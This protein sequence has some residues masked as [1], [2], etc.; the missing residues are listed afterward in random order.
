MAGREYWLVDAGARAKL[1]GEVE[2]PDLGQSRWE[3]DIHV[4][5]TGYSEPFCW[6]GPLLDSTSSVWL[7]GSKGTMTFSGRR[8]FR[9]QDLG[10][11]YGASTEDHAEEDNELYLKEH[12]NETHIY[13]AARAPSSQPGETRE[14]R[15]ARA[16]AGE[17]AGTAYPHFAKRFA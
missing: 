3:I 7:H 11:E 17:G 9:A 5:V 15:V 16:D 12:G 8:T 10:F 13:T 6:K 1:L 2:L 4:T 14:P